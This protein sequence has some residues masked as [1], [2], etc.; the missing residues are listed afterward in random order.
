MLDRNANTEETTNCEAQINELKAKVQSLKRK[1]PENTYED[2]I[3]W[4]AI[5][6]LSLQ[7]LKL[8]LSQNNG[9]QT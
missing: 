9:S 5:D 1:Q 6:S 2:A 4:L 3:K 8:K 7:G